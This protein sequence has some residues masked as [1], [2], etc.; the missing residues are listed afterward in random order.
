MTICVR[1]I[2]QSQHSHI[3]LY[4]VH[5][6]A[7]CVGIVLTTATQSHVLVCYSRSS[8]LCGFFLYCNT[9]TCV[10]ISTVTMLCM[11]SP[12]TVVQ[13]N[14]FVCCWHSSLPSFVGTALTVCRTV[15]CSRVAYTAPCCLKALFQLQHEQLLYAVHKAPCCVGFVLEGA[16]QSHVVHNPLCHLW[17][18][19]N[20]EHSHTWLY[21]V[22]QGSH[23]N[24]VTCVVGCCSQ[25]STLCR[26]VLTA[27]I[28][29]HVVSQGFLLSKNCFSSC[30]L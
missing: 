3:W 11:T 18:F 28:Q 25:A 16:I 2:S 14:E 4:A 26:I 30:R 22:S 12:T 13:S 8:M 6:A 9:V 15:I 17:M 20:L 29:S 10:N 21:V 23:C 24:T 19:Q 1:A 27:A 5:K 7:C